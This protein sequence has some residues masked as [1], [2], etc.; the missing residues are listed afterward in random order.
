MSVCLTGRASIEVVDEVT[1]TL[2]LMRSLPSQSQDICGSP[3]LAQPKQGSEPMLWEAGGVGWVPVV[4]H[5]P[6]HFFSS[7]HT[8]STVGV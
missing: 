4:F 7:T 3:L 2:L 6:E 8:D 1:S 5:F